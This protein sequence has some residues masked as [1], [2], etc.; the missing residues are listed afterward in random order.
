MEGFV[1]FNFSNA[2][3]NNDYVRINVIGNDENYF[4][5]Y[6]FKFVTVVSKLRSKFY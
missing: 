1:E 3:W 5:E 4:E 6:F 2:I